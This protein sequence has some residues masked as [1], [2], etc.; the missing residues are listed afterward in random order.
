MF[1]TRINK[2]FHKHGRVAFG[3]LTLVVIV[4]FVL[5]FS[6][7]PDD[8]LGMFFSRSKKS[9]VSM[10]GKTVSQKKLDENITNVMIAMTLQGYRLNFEAARDQQ[11]ILQEALKRIRLLKAAEERGIL[12]DDL[13][14]AAYIRDL[15]LLQKDGRFDLE[16]YNMF[17][18]YLLREY[19]V[20]NQEIE[21]VARE[22][23]IMD[24]LKEQV[25]DS[26]VVTIAGAREFYDTSHGTYE[27]K[28][29]T[30]N[31]SDYSRS[32]KPEGEEVKK[33]F[34]SKRSKYLVPARYKVN[35]VRFNFIDFE[36][37]AAGKVTDDQV[38]SRYSKDKTTYEDMGEKKAKKKLRKELTEEECKKLAKNKAQQ[39]AVNA[40]KSIENSQ[41]K[42]AL[43]FKEFASKCDYK[44]HCTEDWID[45]ETEL[46]PRLGKL[47][48]LMREI[49]RLYVD[50][51]ITNAILDKNAYFVACLTEKEV[52]R[53]ADFS[54]VKEKVEKDFVEEK[55]A[56]L[57]RKAAKDVL[58][59]VK[60]GLKDKKYKL[61]NRKFKNFP[62]FSQA[63][64]MPVI[65][66]KNGFLVFQQVTKIKEGSISEVLDAPDGA[67]I[68]YVEK[69]TPPL[70]EEFEKDMNTNIASYKA[71]VRR[72]AWS[73]LLLTLE[74]KSNTEIRFST[75]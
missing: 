13:Q 37:E 18:Q 67:I 72:A 2:L 10:Y 56:E 15:P 46:I 35:V 71:A 6:A 53:E 17:V 16:T 12:V 25:E 48:K 38:D 59:E 68:I 50:Q 47:P 45:A 14:V 23:L 62:S 20:G 43:A 28:V 1:I 21:D 75:K 74:D 65:K 26:V 33:Y 54:E 34:D 36:E 41:D 42:K 64:P 55:A 73:N 58:A 29:A 19:R 8:I 9:R 61:K 49:T 60:N 22:N 51:P 11:E 24:I 5:Y 30:F 52:A 7:T 69:I 4:P 57:V 66:E 40:F 3:V 44:V 31:S 70:N 63:D 39:F 27:V 32:V